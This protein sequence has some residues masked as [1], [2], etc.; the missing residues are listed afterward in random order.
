M[1]R[2]TT[3]TRRHPHNLPGELESRVLR[4]G[5]GEPRLRRRIHKRHI[6]LLDQGAIVRPSPLQPTTLPDGGTYVTANGRAR[7]ADGTDQ[8]PFGPF[9]PAVRSLID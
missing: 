4:T 3:P 7:A 9:D 8:F 6:L 2:T 1:G 5:T